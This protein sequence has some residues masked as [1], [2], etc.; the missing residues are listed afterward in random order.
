MAYTGG[1]IVAAFKIKYDGVEILD[2]RNEH[3]NVPHDPIIVKLFPP[4]VCEC[5]IGRGDG[6]CVR[7]QTV[8]KIAQETLVSGRDVEDTMKII[9][10]KMGCQDEACVLDRAVKMKVLTTAEAGIE[11]QIA[12]KQKGPTDASL[13]N[14]SVI[15]AQLYAWMYQFPSFWAYN[16]NMRNFSECC[17]R[18]GRV[19]HQPDT[20]ATLRCCD[21]FEGQIPHPVGMDDTECSMAMLEEKRANG[22]R[23]AACV[24]NSDTYDGT[25]KHWMALFV[26]MR[27]PIWTIEFFNSA[28]IRPESEWMEWM[29]KTKHELKKLKPTAQVNLVCACKIWHQH[30]KTECGPYSLFYVWARLN[31]ISSKYFLD[32]VVPDQLMFEFRQHLFNTD[33]SGQAFDFEKYAAKI[34]VRWDAENI[35]RNKKI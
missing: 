26:D 30:S 7:A 28:A 2:Y 12:F 6:V 11:K 14:D 15:Q 22:M 3:Q 27:E 8:E 21:L 16:F 24:I 10:R 33:E 17:I 25:G 35:G 34:R 23:C 13:F 1:G 20:L 4:I 29:L 31:G 5:A 32:N 19:L 18:S 9:M